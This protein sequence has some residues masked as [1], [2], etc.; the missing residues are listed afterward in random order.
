MT[1]NAALERLIQPPETRAQI[2]TV[3]T[4]FLPIADR[5]LSILEKKNHLNMDELRRVLPEII[6]LCRDIIDGFYVDEFW[7][8]T[9][10]ER[11]KITPYPVYAA[12]LKIG[13]QASLSSELASILAHAFIAIWV[14]VPEAPDGKVPLSNLQKVFLEFR[15]AHLWMDGLE[16]IDTTEPENCYTTLDQ[17]EQRLRECGDVRAAHLSPIRRLLGLSLQK[18]SLIER[19]AR[20]EIGV[21]AGTGEYENRAGSDFE[22]ERVQLDT[23][24]NDE[25][26][27]AALIEALSF[28]TRI[29]VDQD[30]LFQTAER[31]ALPSD[32]LVHR[33]IVVTSQ[34]SSKHRKPWV[35]KNGV[36]RDRVKSDQLRRS[37]QTLT[38]RW[39]RPT[40]YELYVYWKAVIEPV[41]A[42]L[43]AALALLLV[44]L[45]GRELDLVLETQLKSRLDDMPERGENGRIYICYE[46]AVWQ[47]AAPQPL[48]KTQLEAEL[49]HQL[50]QTVPSVQMPIVGPLWNLLERHVGSDPRDWRGA[51]FKNHEKERVAERAAD[52]FDRI[53]K[54]SDV[55]LT[56]RRVQRALFHRL[57][58]G[59]GDMVASILIAG[60]HDDISRHAGIHYYCAYES[61]LQESYLQAISQLVP[62]SRNTLHPVALVQSDRRI[63]SPYCPKPHVL[64]QLATDLKTHFQETLRQPIGKST[65][66]D[67]HNAYTLYTV[68]LL[69]L[70]TGYRSV[71]A[72][73]SRITDVDLNRRYAVIA[74]KESDHWSHSRIVP[75]TENFFSHWD[76]YL[77]HR[78]HV[79]RMVETYL[80]EPAPDHTLFFLSTPNRRMA[81]PIAVTPDQ[82]DEHL[83]SFSS[84]PLNVGRHLLRSELLHR[85]VPALLVDTLMGHWV[86]GREPM[87]R[88]STLSPVEY[89]EILVPVLEEIQVELGWTPVRGLG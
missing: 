77:S 22:M 36:A 69:F 80:G 60:D 44:L 37:N 68:L 62:E 2:Q 24:E 4:I 6:E 38:N 85:R 1:P 42:D 19:R 67:I 54:E 78:R 29:S 8:P 35:G 63:G 11:A 9:S 58:D 12:L 13:D 30:K 16:G 49:R 64:R 3:A 7:H 87:G 59:A 61:A 51:L 27:S 32:D 73:L 23:E 75:L 39:E 41:D 18:E 45:T 83:S 65:L 5:M 88:F 81:K 14:G 79:M 86:A 55:R 17:L 31:N 25:I 50:V 28:P 82:I 66:P 76:Y 47:S 74:D 46:S 89:K 71:Q 56:L 48:R 15:R 33:P 20:A 84:L 43:S 26:D 21:S 34:G 52:F 10:E 57:S 40:E 53:K 70:C 72:P